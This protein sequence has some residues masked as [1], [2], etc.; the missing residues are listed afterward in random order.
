MIK[1]EFKGE[2]DMDSREFNVK[3][4][5]NMIKECERYLAKIEWN[6]KFSA[7]DIDKVISNCMD[8]LRDAVAEWENK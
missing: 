3:I 8:D 5:K 1:S 7:C 4:A 2:F 6:D